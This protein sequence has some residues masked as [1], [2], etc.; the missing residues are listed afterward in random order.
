MGL[1]QKAIGLE[2]IHGETFSESGYY[3]KE[4]TDRK[5]STKGDQKQ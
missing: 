1:K 5:E 4:G 2:N 3:T